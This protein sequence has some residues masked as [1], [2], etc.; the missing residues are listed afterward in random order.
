[1]KAVL[2]GIFGGGG[3]AEIDQREEE[4]YPNISNLGRP[5]LEEPP[6]EERVQRSDAMKE[7]IVDDSPEI[8][9]EQKAAVIHE[10]I[11]RQEV[12][13]IQP[14]IHREVQRTEVYKIIQPIYEDEVREVDIQSKILPSE[15]RPTVQEVGSVYKDRTETPKGT[16]E[17]FEEKETII[18]EP[19]IVEI[20]KKKIIEEI[21]PIIYKQILQPIIVKETKPIYEKVVEA[22]VFFQETR[23]AKIININGNT[24]RHDSDVGLAALLDKSMH[25]HAP[26]QKEKTPI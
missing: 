16:H 13:E 3:H 26:I 8:K 21:Q 24:L 25:I 15:Y 18:K 5:E 12:E 2:Q 1:M 19:I 10:R 11:K 23:E 20:E 14:V 6:I 4:R 17:Y 22:P 9:V 7:T